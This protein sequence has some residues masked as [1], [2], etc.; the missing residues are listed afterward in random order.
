MAP[1]TLDRR[2]IRDMEFSQNLRTKHFNIAQNL[3][4]KK[5]IEQEGAT[6]GAGSELRE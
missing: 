6:V 4:M 5:G 3:F 2:F 1:I